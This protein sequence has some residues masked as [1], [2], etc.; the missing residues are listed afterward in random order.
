MPP[1]KLRNE[2]T[3]SYNSEER[4]LSIWY[5]KDA[6]LE[7]ESKK[8]LY[9]FQ[10]SFLHLPVAA[11]VFIC[12][13]LFTVYKKKVDVSCISYFVQMFKENI[14]DF[15]SKYAEKNVG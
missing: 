3:S 11:I 10:H 12:V 7:P 14:S 13:S 2:T 4:S 15:E 5:F 8:N 1:A 9:I 6:T